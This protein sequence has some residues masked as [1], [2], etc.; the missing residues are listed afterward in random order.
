[1]G[2]AAQALRNLVEAVAASARAQR[3]AEAWSAVLQF[4]VTGERRPL[5]LVVDQGKL[6]AVEGPHVK[7][8][9]VV[10]GEASALVPVLTGQVDITHPI[11][12]G[13]LRVVRGSYND[14]INLSRIALAARA[15]G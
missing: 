1:M 10:A 4:E 9:I 14:L 13:A 5:H 6:A 11:A 2:K 7:P 12:R 3:A 8:D 15:R